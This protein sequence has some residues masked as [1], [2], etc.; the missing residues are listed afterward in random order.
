[1]ASCTSTSIHR[2]VEIPAPLAPLVSTA[3][4][5][6]TVY[7]VLLER[8][9]QQARQE[10]LEAERRVPLETSVQPVRPVLATQE[11]LVPRVL[12]EPLVQLEVLVLPVQQEP[13]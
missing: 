1:M 8:R 5:V 12:P 6:L 4:M 2:V 13:V 10:Q 7:P 9:E 11:Q 3:S